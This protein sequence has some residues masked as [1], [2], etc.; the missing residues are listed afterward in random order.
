MMTRSNAQLRTTRLAT[1][2]TMVVVIAVGQRLA[3]A[4]PMRDAQG[5]AQLHYELSS[6]HA[7]SPDAGAMNAPDVATARSPRD[8]V[9]AGARLHG[10]IGGARLGYHV[11]LDLAAGATVRQA[12]FAYD[13]ALFPV[14]VA[15]RF[16][17]TS[18][19]S[20]GV[21]VGA[22]GAVGTL[23][24]AATFPLEARLELGRGV[25]VLARVRTTYIAG[26]PSRQSGA[27]TTGLADELEATLGLRIGRGYTDWGFPT[28]N[29]YFVGASVRELLGQ[30][31]AGIV[32]GYSIDMGTRSRR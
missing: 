13:V 12:G 9:L 32:I 11:G 14:G 8:H 29:G 18:F 16:A 23:D 19:L 2:A 31:F 27:V 4:Q 20:L 1:L 24:D 15:L 28:G 26:A 25:R 7:L 21:G 30:R 22:S 6:L 3:A 10:F 5:G 17:E